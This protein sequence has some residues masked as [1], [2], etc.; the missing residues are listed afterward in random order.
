MPSKAKI[1]L[2]FEADIKN[3]TI[4]YHSRNYKEQ[5]EKL[6]EENEGRLLEVNFKIID[7][8]AYYCHKYYR[9]YLLPEITS[10]YGERDQAKVHMILKRDFLYMNIESGQIADIQKKYVRQ[11]IY[12]I[13]EEK[14]FNL[15]NENIYFSLIRGCVIVTNTQGDLKGFIPSTADIT[16]KDMKEFILKVEHRLYV[17]MNGRMGEVTDADEAN[18]YRKKGQII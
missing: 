11:G 12:L 18:E 17:E 14:I 2:S 3:R 10:A 13:S 4:H 16:H 6:K 7:G 5:I 9:G 15:I 8:P 1:D